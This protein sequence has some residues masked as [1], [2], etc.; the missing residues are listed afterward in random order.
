MR[1]ISV[2]FAVLAANM[3]A[4]SATVQWKDS[5]SRFSTDLLRKK[6]RNEQTQKFSTIMNRLKPALGKDPTE[7][8]LFV[9]LPMDHFSA[10]NKDTISCRYFVQE[11]YYKPGGPVIFH[12]IG[13][14]SI[15]PYAKGLVDEDEFSVAMAKRFNG[16]LIL[17]EHRF[18]GQSAPTTKTSQSLA[19]ASRRQ[20]TEFFKFHT[21]E[22]ALEDV[23]YFA[24]NFTYDLEEY[25][26]QVLTPDKTPWIWIGVSYSGARGAWMAKR[27]PGLFK[28][29]LASSAP[30]QL[31]VNFWEYFTAIEDALAIQNKN[32]SADLTAAARWL[33]GAWENRDSS[34][35]DQLID[36]VYEKNWEESLEQYDPDS[37]EV[38]DVRRDYLQDAAWTPFADFQYYGVN[39]GTLGVFC[40]I[41]ETSYS[42]RGGPEGVFAAES[43]AR[44]VTAYAK[45]VAAIS[46]YSYTSSRQRAQSKE[47]RQFEIGTE[48]LDDKL[49]DYS[50][51]WQVCTEFGA[52][53]VANTSRPENLLPSFINVQSSIDSCISTFGESEQVSKA[54]PNVDPINQKYQGWYVQ[55]SNTMWTNGEFDPWKALSVDSEEEDA[56]T[57]DTATTDIPQCGKTFPQ[58]TQ[59]RYVIKDGYHGSEFSEDVVTNTPG[60]LDGLDPT[61]TI[62]SLTATRTRT[63]TKVTATGTPVVDAINA[64]NLWFDAMSSWLPC[65]TLQF[66]LDGSSPETTTSMPFTSRTPFPTGSSDE[67]TETSGSSDSSGDKKNAASSIVIPS[68]M[69]PFF[70][71]IFA[72]LAGIRV[73]V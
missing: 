50:W 41:M 48:S 42:D 22:Q 65:T 71:S 60:D 35:V 24:K 44:A 51:L 3:C 56:P 62:R 36:A 63:R 19:Q 67:A 26:K 15:G 28:A 23:V 9:E 20:L 29:T 72:F 59:L 8:P 32:C 5:I 14:S 47:K 37:Q 27:N 34:L 7:N 55:L 52:F 49:D 21:I 68:L 43:L 25:P 31:K 12:D 16:L 39:G 38:W 54:G 2:I 17:F 61:N 40:D 1:S 73:L 64:Q 30:V 69:L 18:Y 70:V 10:D 11:S 45:A 6:H 46:P 66:N 53:Q 33:S 57:N 4:V 58:G 13:E